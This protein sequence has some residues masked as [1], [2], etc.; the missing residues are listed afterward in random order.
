MLT[1]TWAPFAGFYLSWALFTSPRALAPTAALYLFFV[2]KSEKE[3]GWL[4]ERFPDYAEYRRRVRS[5]II[6]GIE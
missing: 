5:R 3:E 1:V 6:P 2:M 4:E